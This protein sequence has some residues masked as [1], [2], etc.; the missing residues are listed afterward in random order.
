M[1][2]DIIKHT[3]FF[4]FGLGLL[5]FLNFILLPF[6]TRYFLPSELGVLELMLLLFTLFHT[7][8][9]FGFGS[10]IFR[11]LAD[12][13]NSKLERRYF[14][15]SAF[16]SLI[17]LA[18]IGILIF[19]Q[20][21][22][23]INKL[24][25]DMNLSRTT[26]QILLIAVFLQIL[27]ALPIAMLRYQKRSIIF[28][29]IQLFRFLIEFLLIL[30]L[31]LYFN[32]SYPSVFVAK[33]ISSF[34]IVIILLFINRRWLSPFISFAKIADIFRYSFFIMPAVLSNIVINFS[35]RFFVKHYL[36][37]ES[38]AYF[39]V[40]SRIPMVL[41]IVIMAFQYIWPVYLFKIKYMKDARIIYG[42]V[43]SYYTSVVGFLA[44]LLI[45]FSDNLV[46]LM[47]TD[48]YSPAISVIKL[49]SFSLVFW[50]M[51][52]SGTAGIHISGKTYF[53]T[54]IMISSATVNVILNI[55]F[56]PIFGINGAAYSTL[57][58]YAIMGIGSVFVSNMIYRIEFE[59]YKLLVILVTVSFVEI[60][61]CFNLF[62][63][64]WIKNLLIL[65]IALGWYRIGLFPIRIN[66]SIRKI[67]NEKL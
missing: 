56:I 30:I 44:I 26:Y 5:R 38:V 53:L 13:V 29:S 15:S 34:I 35:N 7:L 2:K 3:F 60:F 61:S 47:A 42:K 37:L 64:M 49:I 8:L 67:F 6:Y 63:N 41:S 16:W 40:G 48:I 27:S 10:G 50:G 25:F 46:Q 33:V 65:I 31:V 55:C 57:C 22:L 54:I 36:S 23:V 14:F 21:Y 4:G 20:L 62:L 24:L 45:V 17:I 19:N 59:W 9:T 66:G 11:Y 32:Y 39:S 43:F 1:Y 51:Y 58:S 18:I 28:G 12:P 52:Y